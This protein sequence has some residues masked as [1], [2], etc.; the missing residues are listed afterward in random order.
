MEYKI[1]ENNLKAEDLIKLFR[2]AGWGEIPKRIA[3][4]AIR[5]SYA[6]FT[7]SDGDR[8]IAMVRLLG[9]GAMA[10][11][12]K[13]LVVDPEYQGKGVGR[14][15]LT[16]VEDYIRSD[17]EKG[18]NACFQLVSAKDKEGFY[19]KMGFASHP[20]EW[21]GPGYTLMIQGEREV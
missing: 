21:S 3:E 20:N 5:K 9:D 19:N 17:V 4:T 13:D 18:W 7:V 2:C 16:H 12:M 1:I 6:T 10:Y 14:M 15:L 11:F 8:V